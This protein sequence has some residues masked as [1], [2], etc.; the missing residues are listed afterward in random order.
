MPETGVR[1]IDLQNVPALSLLYAW[2]PS[3]SCGDGNVMPIYTYEWG[4][5]SP[6]LPVSISD[7][8]RSLNLHTRNIDTIFSGERAA[9]IEVE[10]TWQRNNV[11]P[12]C[13]GHQPNQ[14]YSRC[15]AFNVCVMT[16]G[17][18]SWLRWDTLGHMDWVILR[19]TRVRST[20]RLVK[21]RKRNLDCNANV[22]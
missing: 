13:F 18:L 9:K 15:D 5:T 22:M 11:T 21:T 8:C 3:V 19:T 6:A 16:V 12:I 17:I 7:E 10:M 4:S 20:R 1:G 14:L 2:K